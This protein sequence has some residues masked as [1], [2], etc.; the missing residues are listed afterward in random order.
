[1]EG[2]PTGRTAV[3]LRTIRGFAV[4]IHGFQLLTGGAEDGF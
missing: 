1:L 2:A 4:A 3:A